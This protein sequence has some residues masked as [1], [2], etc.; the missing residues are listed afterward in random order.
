MLASTDPTQ[1]LMRVGNKAFMS[2]WREHPFMTPL[3]AT[4]PNALPRPDYQ[5]PA[6]DIELAQGIAS[7]APDQSATVFTDP[8]G[9]FGASDWLGY[10]DTGL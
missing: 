7:V 3:L 5:P 2:E 4:K 9:A 6:A 8:Q 10:F 1:G